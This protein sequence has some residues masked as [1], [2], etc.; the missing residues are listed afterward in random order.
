MYLEREV[1]HVWP[2]LP[3][4]HNWSGGMYL[5]PPSFSDLVK[6]LLYNLGCAKL[7]FPGIFLTGGWEQR[8]PLFLLV[9]NL[10]RQPLLPFHVQRL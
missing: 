4:P 10:D 7:S 3:D 2:C 1:H 8:P 6:G 5:L 9:T